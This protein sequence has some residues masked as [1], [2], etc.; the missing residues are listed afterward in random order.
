MTNAVSH[1]EETRKLSA[2]PNIGLLVD[3][4]NDKEPDKDRGKPRFYEF[5]EEQRVLDKVESFRHIHH[6]TINIAAIPE[7]VTD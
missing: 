5:L 6:A 3:V 2:P 1:A 7:E 4:D